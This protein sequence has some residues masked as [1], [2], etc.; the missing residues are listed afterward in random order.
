MLVWSKVSVANVLF[1]ADFL[2]ARRA[3]Q[4]LIFDEY[5]G[6]SLFRSYQQQSE[7]CWCSIGRW[8]SKFARGRRRIDR[9]QGRFA[10]CHEFGRDSYLLSNG[11]GGLVGTITIL[12]IVQLSLLWDT[13]ISSGTSCY[14]EEWY[15][16]SILFASNKT[17]KLQ[18]CRSSWNAPFMFLHLA[19][20]LP[21][22]F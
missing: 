9:L 3:V 19:P 1:G 7:A 8:R 15:E 13:S 14:Q 17:S 20:W 21:W 22:C 4:D 12:V 11:C 2:N 6:A 18:T 5:V 16:S 10:G